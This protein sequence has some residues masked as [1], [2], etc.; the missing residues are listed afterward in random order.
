[1]RCGMAHAL[2]RD[3]ALVAVQHTRCYDLCMCTYVSVKFPHEMMYFY[4]R[5]VHIR[6]IGFAT[7]PV[8]ICKLHTLY[9]L[10][11]IR[12]RS[13]VQRLTIYYIYAV[14]YIYALYRYTVDEL[15]TYGLYIKRM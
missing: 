14:V 10:Q 11:T 9:L 12:N 4:T 13:T 6:Y 2:W 3:G 5:L 7:N 8:Q 1:M 15:Y